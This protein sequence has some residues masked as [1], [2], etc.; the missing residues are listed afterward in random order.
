[1][2]HPEIIF[3]HPLPAG[4]LTKIVQ[5]TAPQEPGITAWVELHG[6]PNDLF[7]GIQFRGFVYEVSNSPGAFHQHAWSGIYEHQSGETV[8]VVKGI[9]K[10]VEA[11]HGMA[12][13]HKLI[14]VQVIRERFDISTVSVATIV[15][16]LRPSAFTV[17]TMVNS[18]A[19]ILL[20]QCQAHNVPG[21]RI[22]SCSV[23]KY[24][25][26]APGGAPVQIVEPHPRH[27]NFETFGQY[28]LG[29]N[30]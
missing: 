23:E 8:A 14:E 4:F 12:H 29:F 22:E 6:L 15:G 1:M 25:G 3:P 2:P 10:G 20:P 16:V 9:V 18:K 28:D 26:P 30:A 11:T 21:V 7:E 19:M 13:K 24:D 27:R 5:Q 17:P